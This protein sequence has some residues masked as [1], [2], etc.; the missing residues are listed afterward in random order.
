MV[1]S[2]LFIIDLGSCERY[3]DIGKPG[4]PHLP[5]IK[6]LD[7]IGSRNSF[8]ASKHYFEGHRLTRRDDII[9]IVYNL[10]YL[11]QPVKFEMSNVFLDADD[12]YLA[13][14]KYKLEK[15]PA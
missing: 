12:P 13:M 3:I 5:D 8:F 10:L 14:K 6:G 2:N 4:K 9:Q 15:T 1:A 7:V 11:T